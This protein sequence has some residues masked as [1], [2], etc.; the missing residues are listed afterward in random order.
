MGL[1]DMFGSI[2]GSTA[3]QAI[4]YGFSKALQEN[5]YKLNLKGLRESP[6]AQ[7]QGLE[8]AGYNPILAVNSSGMANATASGTAGL[9][10]NGVGAN[11]ASISNARRLQKYEQ[12]KL[13]ADTQNAIAGADAQNANASLAR[14][15][16]ITEQAKRDNLQ[17]QNSMLDVQKHLAQK[18][19][20]WYDRKAYT[21]IYELMQ[22]A[23]NYRAMQSIASFNA[24]TDR[25]NA[26]T[27]AKN[28]GT[29]AY[30][31]ETNRINGRTNVAKAVGTGVASAVGLGLFGKSRFVKPLIKN[32]GSI[33]KVAPKVIKF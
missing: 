29:N 27:N 33:V 8:S 19:L 1:F 16:A 23:E 26:V 9:S 7:R 20:D 28:A 15:Q 32:S 3:G 5:Q 14:E 22:R 31:A 4:N 21:Q 24:Q 13:S 17:F 25:Q 18:D 6:S 12:S 10:D 30:N 2:F 11:F